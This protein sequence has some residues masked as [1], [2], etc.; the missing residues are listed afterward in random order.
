MR[1]DDAPY[2]SGRPRPAP[3]GLVRP[4]DLGIVT[5]ASACRRADHSWMS[6]RAQLFRV[7]LTD[8]VVDGL[9]VGEVDVPPGELRGHGLRR[10]PGRRSTANWSAGR[11]VTAAPCC[12][13]EGA[14]T[15]VM[16]AN[17]GMSV[18]SDARAVSGIIQGCDLPRCCRYH[19]RDRGDTGHGR[20]C[21]LRFPSRLRKQL[22]VDRE[23]SR[24]QC[25]RVSA[26]S[27]QRRGRSYDGD[28]P[29][30]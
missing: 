10:T 9:L 24:S 8:R 25:A 26:P 7:Q 11:M 21:S 1:P 28:R 16:R 4:K 3:S 17:R 23:R 2:A 20:G 29:S 5:C 14:S 22:E 18:C 12:G 19:R 15:G 30:P 27:N 13:V 6:R